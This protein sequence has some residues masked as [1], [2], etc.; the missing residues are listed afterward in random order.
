MECTGLPNI[1]KVNPDNS[2][3]SDEHGGGTWGEKRWCCCQKSWSNGYLISLP[4]CLKSASFLR[5]VLPL[6]PPLLSDWGDAFP[7]GWENTSHFQPSR[8]KLATVAF[9]PCGHARSALWNCSQHVDIPVAVPRKTSQGWNARNRDEP[10]TV[11]TPVAKE[12]TTGCL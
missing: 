4:D 7:Q 11:W 10:P 3:G 12:V 8:A 1:K 9:P 5:A 2:P 6:F